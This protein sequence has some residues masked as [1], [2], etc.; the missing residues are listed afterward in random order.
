MNTAA[1]QNLDAMWHGVF[2]KL[3]LNVVVVQFD[4]QRASPIH[5]HPKIEESLGLELQQIGAGYYDSSFYPGVTDPKRSGSSWHFFHAHDLGAAMQR[6]K[7]QLAARGLLHVA[8]I[9]H[10]EES[11]QLRFWYSYDPE[12]IGRL[13]EG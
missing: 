3:G 2:S 1:L 10:A 13:L 9:L 4:T 6:L 5:S 11:N 12:T 7:S 8:N